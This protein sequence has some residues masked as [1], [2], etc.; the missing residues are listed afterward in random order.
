ME[1]VLGAPGDLQDVIGLVGL[2][3]TERGADPGRS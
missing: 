2:A 1:A 3:V